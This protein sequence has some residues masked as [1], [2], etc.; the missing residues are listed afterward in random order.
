ML[1]PPMYITRHINTNQV[2]PLR[3]NRFR[4]RDSIVSY[5]IYLHL[6]C[7]RL[8]RDANNA[9]TSSP[10]NVHFRYPKLTSWVQEIIRQKEVH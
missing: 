2:G 9:A 6:A 8:V 5:P 1:I 10:C 4:F 3:Y 7:Q